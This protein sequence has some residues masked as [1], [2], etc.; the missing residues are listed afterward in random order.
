[1]R[2]QDIKDIQLN[3]WGIKTYDDRQ[4]RYSVK[5]RSR[6]EGPYYICTVSTWIFQLQKDIQLKSDK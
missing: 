6:W 4:K 1:M 5:L 2:H 3:T